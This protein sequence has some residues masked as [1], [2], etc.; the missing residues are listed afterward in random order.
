MLFQSILPLSFKILKINPAAQFTRIPVLNGLSSFTDIDQYIMVS[1]S[2][3]LWSCCV[4]RNLAG[5]THWYEDQS[6]YWQ[7]REEVSF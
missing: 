6:W 5:F 4:L 3:L 2:L 1:F 7:P